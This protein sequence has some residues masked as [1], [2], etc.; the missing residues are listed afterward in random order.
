MEKTT[1]FTS[2]ELLNK[3]FSKASKGYD[4]FE[5]DKVLDQII[6]DYEKFENMAAPTGTINEKLVKELEQLKKENA[7]IKAELVKER[8]KWKYISK[9]HKNIHIDNYELLIRIGKLEMLIHEKLGLNPEE[10]K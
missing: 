4:P 1:N 6:E 9:D 5:V 2:E 8:N 7:E 3:Q 10:I